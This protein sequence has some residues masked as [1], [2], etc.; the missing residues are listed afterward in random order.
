ME[1]QNQLELNGR[2][3]RNLVSGFNKTGLFPIDPARPKARIPHQE[4]EGENASLHSELLISILS[5]MRDETEEILSDDSNDDNDIPLINLQECRQPEKT[6]GNGDWVVVKYEQ[7]RSS[8]HFVGQIITVTENNSEIS[9]S[10]DFLKKST[11][12]DHFLKPVPKDSD[13]ISLDMILR[14]L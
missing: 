11:K 7:H 12:T 1:L 13:V 6:P 2:G 3:S 9:I 8:G 4:N 14:F 5:E 10:V